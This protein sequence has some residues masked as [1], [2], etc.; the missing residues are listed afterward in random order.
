MKIV[1]VSSEATPFARTGILGDA[2]GGLAKGLAANGHEVHLI[3]PRYLSVDDTGC[4]CR[5]DGS[6]T[7]T[8]GQNSYTFDIYKTERDGVKY[9]F[10]KNDEL[11]GRR[12]MYGSANFDYSD[13]DIRFGMFSLA[14]LEYMRETKL[15][16][17]IIHCHEWC[18]GLVSVYRN[19]YYDDIKGKIVFTAHDI[20]FQGIFGKYSVQSLGLPW[21][22]YNIEELEYYE[23]ISLL[24]GGMVHA[25]YI[26]VPSPTYC[27]D[28]QTE[29][30]SQ[31]L[32]LLMADMRDKLTGIFGG[33]DYSI[34]NP[35]ED[36][37]LE[38]KYDAES[39]EAKL[40]N[41]EEFITKTGLKDA[42]RPL[43]MVET[44]FTERKGLELIAQSAE[45]L[46][47]LNANF[48]FFG[49]G[50][51]HLCSKFKEIAK[52][53]DNMV[54]FIGFNKELIH[55]G[56]AAAD[57]TLRPSQY[58][59]SGN[60]HL[61]GM[62]YGALPV[63]SKTGGHIDSV[64]D[65]SDGGYGFFIEEYSRAEVK[66]QINRAIAFFNNKTI[67]G[68]CR[69]SVMQKDFSVNSASLKYIELYGRLL[70]GGY[71]S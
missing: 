41:K 64:T 49:Y 18:T 71:E 20:T 33:I 7:V 9:T 21:S 17:D 68:E 22:V 67:L 38:K 39:A 29:E 27:R 42:S 62:R 52:N 16:A 30:F 60:S 55:L 58:E 26:T 61:K 1:M 47:E 44:K 32:G 63:V 43:F 56:Y 28:I 54:T 45:E 65:V 5:H 40:V 51:S 57:F 12:Y 69:K 19:L 35:A 48:A 31:G 6:V 36:D 2:V 13:N 15:N 59:P 53:H 46:A 34:Y 70:G 66:K 25:D 37:Y 8:A 3:L 14:S 4:G 50:E 23:G 24:K 10:L 11:Y